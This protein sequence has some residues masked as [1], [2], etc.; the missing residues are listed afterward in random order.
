MK[1]KKQQLEKIKQRKQE[2]SIE[3]QEYVANTTFEQE[4]EPEIE[5]EQ[6]ESDEE[7][8]AYQQSQNQENQELVRAQNLARK[9]R[10]MQK[11]AEFKT[12]SG[13]ILDHMSVTTSRP[14]CNVNDDLK[15]EFS[16]MEQAKASTLYAI[17]EFKKIKFEFKRPSDYFAE[18][19][20]SD[21][22]M[23]KV[24]EYVGS[25]KEIEGNVVDLGLKR[26]NQSRG[27]QGDVKKTRTSEQVDT[28]ANDATPNKKPK[29]TSKSLNKNAKSTPNKN[30]KS[31]PNKNASNRSTRQGTKSVKSINKDKKY[32]M[33]GKKKHL[34]SNTRDSVNDF[35]FPKFNKKK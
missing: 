17:A 34:K 6:E 4:S 19:I 8:R 16:F 23:K 30:A 9:Q 7:L 20:K 5:S 2:K 21:E 18:M 10:I 26:K 31:S 25:S 29:T 11:L 13:T 1:L 32:G 3:I 24:V 33:G 14:E 12:N 22:H 28:L 15:R 35:D 27:K